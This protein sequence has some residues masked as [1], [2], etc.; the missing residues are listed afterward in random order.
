MTRGIV[1]D[2]NR[3]RWMA[4]AFV[5][6]KGVIGPPAKQPSRDVL[7][8]RHAFKSVGPSCYN[9]VNATKGYT[10]F[11]EFRRGPEGQWY[12]RCDYDECEWQSRVKKPHPC[13][14][15]RAACLWHAKLTR[16]AGID[17]PALEGHHEGAKC[18]NCGVGRLMNKYHD[19]GWVPRP[20]Q[21]TYFV[22]WFQ[23]NNCLDN[24]HNEADR[25]PI[26]EWR[27]LAL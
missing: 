27:S 5:S 3:R 23:C 17:A 9:V 20:E 2:L 15:I 22:R 24:F 25:R 12:A 13:K 6:E 1:D 4:L 8:V 7:F 21:R 14:H 10:C 11:V 19:D 26:E 16:R 18:S